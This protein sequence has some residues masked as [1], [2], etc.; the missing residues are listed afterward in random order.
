MN[1]NDLINLVNEIKDEYIIEADENYHNRRYKKK[2]FIA[3]AVVLTVVI[4]AS[5]MGIFRNKTDK[6]CLSVSAEELGM[7]EYTFG[8][9]LPRVIYADDEKLIMYDYRGI[10]VY[11]IKKS[12]LIGYADFRP[13]EMTLIQG[14]NPTFVEASLDGTYVRFYN[15]EKKYLYIVDDD[16]IEEV[17]EYGNNDK[18]FYVEQISYEDANSL[19]DNFPTYK[20]DDKSYLSVVIEH[21][22]NSDDNIIRYRDLRIIKKYGGEIK[23]YMVFE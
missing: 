23:R 22:D 15:I 16:K 21:D 7:E 10:Y 6:H 12:E 11:S 9:D 1:S 14:D 20:L 18:L 5:C 19:S 2:I 13:I 3:A 8:V 17:D 4:G